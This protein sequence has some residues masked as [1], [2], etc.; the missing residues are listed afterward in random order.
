MT[1]P[2]TS[3]VPRSPI[4]VIE[5]E[6]SVAAFLRAALE[7]HGYKV[8]ASRSAAEALTLLASSRF[9]G[10]ISD[11]HMPGGVGGADVKAW[12]QRNRPE[13]AARMIF[14]TGDIASRETICLLAEAGAP[15][16]EK[17]FRVQ[18][19]MAAVEGTIGKP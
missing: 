2:A 19:L 4:L 10:V 9:A 3:T 11:L 18:Q 5:D 6:P 1:L 12:L 7:R 17:P 8:A 13:L 15:C 16:I 14:I